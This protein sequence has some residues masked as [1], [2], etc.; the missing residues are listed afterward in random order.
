MDERLL[1]WL[2]QL[3]LERYGAAFAQHEVTFEI[4]SELTA[5]DLKE[6][7]LPV[8]PRRTVLSAVAAMA[9][10]SPL[11]EAAPAAD[12]VHGALN[13]PSHAPHHQGEAQAK[14]LGFSSA[15]RGLRP[16]VPIETQ[17][18]ERRLLT[19]VFCDMVGY[20]PLT[21]RFDPEDVRDLMRQFQAAVV[22]AMRAH[23]GHIAAY[24][25]DGVLAFFGWP[26]AFEDQ[27]ERATCAALD[28]VAAVAKLTPQ[29][30]AS[31][32][33]RA[34]IATGRVVVGSLGENNKS[35]VGEAVNLAQ[36]LQSF[37]EPGE[38][39][40]DHQ[41][42]ELIKD[43][44]ILHG[45][46][47]LHLKGFPEP[48]PASIVTGHSASETRFD[49][50]R[51]AR[52]LPLVGRDPELEKLAAA[53]AHAAEGRGQLVT[54]SG[55]A[56]AGKSRLLSAF[57]QSLQAGGDGG[58]DQTILQYQCLRHYTNS[59][60][61]PI[62]QRFLRDA[63]I[64]AADDAAVRLSKL[65]RVL[66]Q[67]SA[68]LETDLPLI[69]HILSTPVDPP[70]APAD[71]ASPDF[72]DHVVACVIDQAFG[73]AAHRPL[74]LVLEDAHWIDPSTAYLL[75]SLLT[76]IKDKPIMVI[77]THR[78]E[79]EVTTPP[80]VRRTDIT[81][82]R[83]SA[84]ESIA[85][86]KACGGAGLANHV[87]TAIAARAEGIPL[88]VEELTGQVLESDDEAVVPLSIQALFVARLDRLGDDKWLAQ[89]LSVVGRPVGARFIERL[90]ELDPARL[91][92]AVARLLASGL[93]VKTESAD[94]TR[95]RFKH[96]LIQ[97]AA[98]DTLL[99]QVRREYHSRIA[100]LLVSHY[101][102][103]ALSEPEAVARHLS[104]GGRPG[105]AINHWLNAGDM[106]GARS[107]PR[108]AVA[109]FSA[110]LSDLD[111]MAPSATRDATEFSIRI[112]LGA[113]LLTLE[114][115]SSPAVAKHYDRALQLSSDDD[116]AQ[117][118]FAAL[119]GKANVL[120]LNGKLSQCARVAGQLTSLAQKAHDSALRL[121]ALVVSGMCSLLAGRFADAASH[122]DDAVSLYD[123]HTHHELAFRNGTDPC[124]VS[125]AGLSWALWFLG[126]AEGA[127]ARRCEAIALAEELNH[128][129]SLAYAMSLSANLAQ[130]AN[131]PALTKERASES[132]CFAQENDY[133]YWVAWGRIVKGWAMAKLGSAEAG[134]GEVKDGVAQYRA[135]GARQMLPYARMLLA[136]CYLNAGDNGA[137]AS[138]LDQVDRRADGSE[139]AFFLGYLSEFV[140]QLPPS[141][142]PSA[143]PRQA[144]FA[145]SDPVPWGE[146]TG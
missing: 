41:T 123:R 97:E 40:V 32:E 90:T 127:E 83:L 69:A 55:E 67:S 100:D 122:L 117:K 132:I 4:L 105:E 88:Y 39:I 61:Y 50:G 87:L 129:F 56:G 125:L 6:L 8:G 146:A 70:Y 76:A 21:V 102:L 5:E 84:D 108:E 11:Q 89:L 16:T 48:L 34:G 128:P 121:S 95:Y 29:I 137:C 18:A 113:S 46:G 2:R 43:T 101:P 130:F 120:L 59:P 98:Y 104:V 115:W 28:A 75:D 79:Y 94:D 7:G 19:V 139:A 35:V 93:L 144:A 110:G 53:F 72:L 10:A 24:L 52:S 63:G 114:G 96:V 25:G 74:C 22:A 131:N 109:L 112:G 44:F 9:G 33:L 119:R 143:K 145:G 45:V 136:E 85:L 91:D 62:K 12:G 103:I 133:P 140:E 47:P 99:L 80:S 54:L 124:V 51:A 23:D 58:T 38:T 3:G 92:P 81:L 73:L 57:R 20:T 126:D 138:E 107:A 111:E 14:G 15:A 135:T 36:R 26:L 37:A 106:A 142:M 1:D 42:A 78:P 86:A 65:E 49:G 64:V 82:G 68:N 66:R 30:D 13:T 134:I 77:V 27:A 17:D 141:A 71:P 31:T 118:L 60:L 116:D